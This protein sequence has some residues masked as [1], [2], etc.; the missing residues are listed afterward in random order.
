M[1][2]TAVPNAYAQEDQCGGL[3]IIP[4]LSL[5]EF[6]SAQL[7]D[8]CIREVIAQLQTG[9]SPSS[10]V[11]NA[12]PRLPYLLREK[13]RLELLDGI[14]YRRRNFAGK[15]MYQLVLPEKFHQD[16]LKS[17][18]DDLGHMGVDRTLDLVRNRFYWS[19]MA[20]DVEHKVRTCGRCTRRKVLPEKAAPL[21]NISTTRPLQLVCMDF[22]SLEPDQS[23][24]KDVLVITD[25]FT[26][27]A[28]AIPTPNQKAKTVAKCLWEQFICHYGYPERLHSDQGPDFESHL[29]KE[30]C[31]IAGVQKVRTTPYHPRGNPVERFN[32]T[33]LSMLGTLENKK[34]SH[35]KEY[36]KPLVHAY[37]CTRNETTGFS[38]YELMFRRQP[39]LPV[40]LAFGLPLKSKGEITH[41]QYVK[42]LKAHLEES[43]R[44]ASENS[45]KMAE[46]NKTR[47]DKFVRASTLHK[48]D[49]VL[50][51]SVRL[52]GKNKL[53]D[54]WEGVVY[55]VIDQHGD[56]PVYK[57]C[58]E[59][60]TGPTRTL[61]RD[62]LLPCGSLPSE[63][64]ECESQSSVPERKTRSKIA[65]RNSEE[66]EEIANSEE[67]EGYCSVP[68]LDIVNE[69]F[70]VHT[71]GVTHPNKESAVI[72]SFEASSEIN[73]GVQSELPVREFQVIDELSVTEPLS[74]KTD[75]PENP[76]IQPEREKDADM[77][78][79]PT[80]DLQD[81]NHNGE[82]FIL[83]SSST[84]KKLIDEETNDAEKDEIELRRSA[85]H[86][87]KPKIL[88]YPELGNPLVT[89]VQSLLQ[90]LNVALS[91][92]LQDSSQIGHLLT[93][94][95]A[96]IGDMQRDL[97]NSKRGGC[98][99]D[100]N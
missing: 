75:L 23:N 33:L 7:A 62:L 67:E 55:V 83:E 49:R 37:N 17:L 87:E 66:T 81:P 2:E 94:G 5:S 4:H 6:Q 14:L 52:R 92:S 31:E 41:S 95:Y 32:R 68:Q 72:P 70:V 59:T 64:G 93:Q 22:L 71:S 36:V 34:K 100:S 19:K 13:D 1:Q 69:S 63:K 54:K 20:S 15:T 90:G 96:P 76:E 48:G 26:K 89:I 21:V 91:E 73:Q 25:H 86:R 57:V 27:Y 24:T 98:N 74:S 80:L 47:Y 9:E 28:L 43:F 79:S 53:A 42:N 99:P 18:H 11:R 39:R 97:H 77:S 30:L 85:R 78:R 10:T 35:W 16:V 61:H 88:T 12:L 40:D 65:C 84:K 82:S 29:I 45:K 44:I 51:R 56:L 38:P 60:Q 3:P 58:P 8:P 46:R 50:V